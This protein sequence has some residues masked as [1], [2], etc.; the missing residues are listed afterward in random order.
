MERILAVIKKEFKHIV[1][2]K[3]SLGLLVVIPLLM[4]ILFGF[5][6]SF[7][8]KN[9]KL[10]VVDKAKT[11]QSRELVDKFVKTDYFNLHS[12]ELNEKN[13]YNK[14]DKKETTTVMI[15]PQNYSK[16]IKKDK[17]SEVMFIID[18]VDSNTASTI[19]GYIS[20]IVYD[21]NENL[22][23]E[24]IK[25]RKK[26]INYKPR[27]WY[28]PELKSQVFLVPGLIVYI[29]MIITVVSTSLTIVKEREENTIEQ[30]IVS[31]L[32]SFQLIIGKVIP[33]VIITFLS[34]LLII[35]LGYLVFDVA[36]K[37]SILL[38]L[39]SMIIFL[40]VGV[41]FGLMISAISDSQ[42]FAFMISVLTTILPTLLLS[43]FVFPIR[44]MAKPIQ[45]F[46]Y[47]VPAKYFMEILRGIIIKGTGIK[48]FWPEFLIMSLLA[49][50]LLFVSS[51]KLK[52]KLS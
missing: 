30:L 12:Y 27:I 45:L 18:G 48:S 50:V 46:T 9:V 5:A 19:Q 36:V 11:A 24:F 1:R 7:D 28:N 43:G 52:K 10:T 21:V 34:S 2:D 20:K 26:T 40:I 47:L 41:S 16:K 3:R 31:P 4:L 15:I 29:L 32:Y 49:V 13:I 33:Y 14:L 23:P 51:K 42:Q 38:L 25:K 35:I 44:N 6:L 22:K 8:V 37:G 17:K 39:I